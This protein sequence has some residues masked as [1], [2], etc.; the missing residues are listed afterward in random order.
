MR[1]DERG[2]RGDEM[3]AEKIKVLEKVV[4]LHRLM[5]AMSNRKD[6]SEMSLEEL[7]EAVAWQ[8]AINKLLDVADAIR[9]K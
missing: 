7:K 5:N 4:E 8:G 3:T 2:T 6:G 1:R 9:A